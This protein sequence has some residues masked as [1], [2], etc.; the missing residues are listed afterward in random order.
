[1]VSR[2]RRLGGDVGFL[3]EQD[4]ICGNYSKLE[5]SMGPPT[6]HQERANNVTTNTV[7]LLGYF[8]EVEKMKMVFLSNL[9]KTKIKPAM[10]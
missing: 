6:L 7:R 2:E 9:S 8:I 5:L 3:G 4:K 1:M 10:L